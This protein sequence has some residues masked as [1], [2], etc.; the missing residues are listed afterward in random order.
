MQSRKNIVLK[1]FEFCLTALDLIDE[2]V[3][4]GFKSWLL[5]LDDNTEA[6]LLETLLL[7]RE[8]DDVDLGRNLRSVVRIAHPSGDVQLEFLVIG[9]FTVSKFHHELVTEFDCCLIEQVIE[10]R[11]KN[12]EDIL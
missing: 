3:L 11:V 1:T 5:F 8:V 6:L 2:R 9:Y 10:R 12:L 4:V 7:D